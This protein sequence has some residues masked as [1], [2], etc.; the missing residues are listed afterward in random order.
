M[1]KGITTRQREVLDIIIEH[2]DEKGYAPSYREIAKRMDIASSSTIQG[3]LER[4]KSKGLVT[5][6]PSQPRTLKVINEKTAS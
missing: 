2:Y 5:W 3:Y 4:L 1:L 6:E